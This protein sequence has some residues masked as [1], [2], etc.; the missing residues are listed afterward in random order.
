VSVDLGRLE[1]EIKERNDHQVTKE[2]QPMG[3]RKGGGGVSAILWRDK[4]AEC[5][6]GKK[7]KKRGRAL[8][9]EYL[10]EIW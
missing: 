1:T 5:N 9:T 4:L 6:P 8:S 2:G 7:K 3:G 10:K